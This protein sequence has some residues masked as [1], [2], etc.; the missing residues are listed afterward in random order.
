MNETNRRAVLGALGSAAAWAIARPAM[1]QAWPAKPIRFLVPYPVGGIVDIVTRA[2]ADPMQAD[3]G[4]PLVVEPKPG[5]NSTLATTMIPQAPADGYNW[6]MAT[7]S[8]VVVPHLQP[9]PYDPLAD[10]QP[11][12]LVAVATSVATVNPAVPAKTLKELVEYG[13]ANPGK[14]NY[15]NPGNGSSIH[16]SAE[17]LKVRYKFDMTS[18]PYRGIPPGMTD[19]IEG[20]LQVGLLPV[21]LAAQHIQAGKLGALA[22]MADQ[23]LPTLPDVRTY[24]ETGFADAQVLSWYVIAVRAGT[25]APIVERLHA[26]A[27]KA[28][29]QADTR[30]RLAKA[31]CEVP[32]PRSPAEIA[33]LWK[34]DFARYGKL[35]QEAG[36]KG[37]S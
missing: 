19:L 12:A 7:I 8:H 31:G 5:A 28:L 16:L 34:A 10:F 23:R 29:A 4:Q 33:A 36:I 3:L 32:A 20:R 25:P 27:M 17:L 9:V 30:D 6:V 1:A 26:S 13:K 21:T 24:A 15:L 14:L 18:V 37:E 22:V 11:V 35:V 2:L